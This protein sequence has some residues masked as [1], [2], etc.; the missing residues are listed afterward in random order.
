MV[1]VEMGLVVQ[2]LFLAPLHLLAVVSVVMVLQ[3]RY[4]EAMAVL[5][6]AHIMEEM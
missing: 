2:I 5:V 1:A 6:A 4:R 3:E